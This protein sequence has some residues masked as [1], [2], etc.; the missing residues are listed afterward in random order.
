MVAREGAAEGVA[1]LLLAAADELGADPGCELYLVSRERDKPDVVWVSELW[2]SQEDLEAASAKAREGDGP[3]AVREAVERF[4]VIELDLLG[5]KGA[6]SGDDGEDRHATANIDDAKDMAAEHGLSE[7]HEA[8]F[9]AGELASEQTGL[10]H[11]RLKPGKRQPFAHRHG[12][13]EEVYVVLSGSG[14]VKLDS[15]VSVL[16]RLDAV[17]VSPGVTR[18]FEA[19]QEG[20]ELLAFGPRHTGDAEIVKDFWPASDD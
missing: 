20:L 14:R 10:A 1:E 15:E 4:E 12:R 9:L 6:R 17:R 18:Q 19:G 11:F 5:G 13:A 3:R 16:A 7:F 2:R 8:R